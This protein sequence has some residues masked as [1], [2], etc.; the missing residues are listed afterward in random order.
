MQNGVN[1]FLKDSISTSKNGFTPFKKR[2]EFN[3]HVEFSLLLKYRFSERATN[4]WSYFHLV[5]TLLVNVKSKWK[6]IPNVCGL[7]R[8]LEL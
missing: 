5:L 2:N 4:I 8:K 6:I 7:L 3:L 1:Y